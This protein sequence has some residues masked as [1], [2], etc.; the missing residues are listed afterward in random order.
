MSLSLNTETP[1]ADAAQEG[2]ADGLRR[3]GEELARGS[4]A[5]VT[6]DAPVDPAMDP[7]D[8]AQILRF[9]REALSNVARHAAAS[10]VDSMLVQVEP[11][12]AAN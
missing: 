12:L 5:A 2:L 8:V 7:A 10:H 3:L 11:G 9:A 1:G 6:V 4:S